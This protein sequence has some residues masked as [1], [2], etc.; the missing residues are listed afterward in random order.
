MMITRSHKRSTSFMLCEASSTS[1]HARA[2]ALE[3]GATHPPVVG[4]EQRSAVE[5]QHLRTIEERFG[6]R[7]AGLLPADSLPRRQQIGEVKLRRQGRQ[8]R[9]R[10]DPY[11][12]QTRRGSAGPVNAMGIPHTTL[13]IHPVQHA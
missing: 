7:H 4:I 9:G 8:P 6:E 5:Q 13:E 11:S 10:L 2:V 1:R 3:A 12:R